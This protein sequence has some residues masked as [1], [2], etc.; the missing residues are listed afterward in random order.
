MA[1][2]AAKVEDLVVVDVQ[3]AVVVADVQAAVVVVD[4]QAAVVVAAV[5]AAVVVAAVQAAA[6]DPMEEIRVEAV[7]ADVTPRE[8]AA[9]GNKRERI[10]VES[11][12]LVMIDQFMLANPQFTERLEDTVDGDLSDKDHLVKDY[13]GSV[14]ELAPGTY[15]I[16]R[17][18]IRSDDYDSP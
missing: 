11:G 10:A 18:S 2:A 1:D 13:G 9:S 17:G 15:R 5:Q 7:E 14:V 6:D 12:F 3:A 16:E 8:M 4:V